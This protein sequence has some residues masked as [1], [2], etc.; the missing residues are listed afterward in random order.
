[1]SVTLAPRA[2]ISVNASWPGV[3]TK[4][5]ARPSLLDAVGA[6][7]L[8]DAA[9]FVRRHVD[10]DD[11]VQQRRLAVV[12]V[13]EERDD[14][15]PRLQLRRVVLLLRATGCTCC[16]RSD[17]AV[18]V[19][20]T[21]PV[22]TASSSAI[23]G[24]SVAAM[25]LIVPSSS[26]LARMVRAG[27]PMASE[28]LRTVQG[29]STRDV[30]AARRRRVRAGPPDVRAPARERGRRF[31]FV[32]FRLSP[33][34]GGRLLA[35]QLPLLAAA[36]RDGRLLLPP[37]STARRTAAAARP[38]AAAGQRRLQARRQ[39]LRRRPLPRGDALGRFGG[40]PLLLV[41]AEMLGKR[42][43]ARL[44]GADRVAWAA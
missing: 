32:V 33:P 12:D 18:E 15:R 22:P 41:L 17:G 6:D 26:S 20:L 9:L 4:A 35:L 10:A 42:L 34:D 7:V 36:E 14:R 37:S 24:S 19:D 30:L 27:T 1:M 21:R 38:L 29:S 13:A 40:D 44:A 11:P 8:R 5:I 28:K 2:R 3:S 39:R 25:L 43:R 16:S 23:S 31:F